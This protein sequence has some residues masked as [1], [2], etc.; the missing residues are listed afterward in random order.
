MSTNL[1]YLE[2]QYL[3]TYKAKVTKVDQDPQYGLYVE[4]SDTVF[5]PQGGGQPTD[6]GSIKSQESSYKVEKVVFAE[7]TVRHY[8]KNEAG[9]LK[10][11]DEVELEIDWDRRYLN[12]RLHTAGHLIDIAQQ[13]LGLKLKPVKGFHYPEGPYVEYEGT[14]TEDTFKLVQEKL[15]E[16]VNSLIGY[17][18]PLKTQQVTKEELVK[19]CGYAPEYLPEGKPVRIVQIGDHT[20]HPCGGTHVGNTS[21]VVAMKITQVKSKSGNTRINYQLANPVTKEPKSVEVA[22]QKAKDVN[23]D[24]VSHGWSLQV[25]ASFAQKIESGELRDK[26][27]VK[28]LREELTNLMKTIPTLPNDQ[29][30]VFGKEI[31][32]AKKLLDEKVAAAQDVAQQKEVKKV[33]VTAPFDINT[34]V[35][36]RPKLYNEKGHKHPLMQE[37]ENI[38]HIF[39]TMGFNVLESRQ[40]D[41]DYHMFESLNFPKGHPA[42]DMYDS[43]WTDENLTPP[44]HTSTM[45]NR[46]L[47]SSNPPI[48]YV[49]PGMCYR[50]EATDASHEHTLYQ[51][52]GVYVDKG[53]SFADMIGTIKT[54]LEA[55]FQMD[56]EY[57]IKTGFFPFVEPGAEFAI[58]CP[59]C[60]KKGCPICGNNGWIELMGCGMIHPNVLK[61]GGIDPKIYSGFAWGFGLDRIV[62][63]KN[64]IKD[65]R[66]FRSGDLEFLKQF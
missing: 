61:E 45:Q 18:L 55:F 31:N 36:K 11:G 8:G 13:I 43:F 12:M 56:L 37:L 40:L 28:S 62:M 58:S 42:R 32:M 47:R 23:H 59:F 48:R 29:K 57:K 44:A 53:V 15:E 38:L 39:E 3:K 1:P 33:D 51:I 63:I 22:E 20:P 35:E 54:Y 5:Y 52:E 10:V 46:A 17:K 66:R 9:E 30:G 19:L 6:L 14:L 41:D 25:I 49:I 26:N 4:L 16:M 2:D 7:G 21:E 65:V 60:R 24:N 50:N 27:V 34:P 64:G